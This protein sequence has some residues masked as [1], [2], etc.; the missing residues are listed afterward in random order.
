MY[1]IQDPLLGR[2]SLELQALAR[3]DNEG[4]L[5][6]FRFSRPDPELQLIAVYGG[7][8]GKR[9]S[10][11]GD[12]GADPHDAFELKT[13][14]C[15]YNRYH[16]R[17][18]AFQLWYGASLD[19][20]S[21][22]EAALNDPANRLRTFYGIFPEEAELQLGN[23]EKP[24]DLE[25][26]LKA[27]P[28]PDQPLLLA[29]IPLNEEQVFFIS[30]GA[31]LLPEASEN[32]QIPSPEK[33]SAR[34]RDNSLLPGQKELEIAYNQALES[35]SGI[36]GRLKITCPDPYINAMGGAL[37]M[38]ADAIWESP[39]YLHGSIGWRS[40]L[41]GWRGAYTGD[42]LGWHDRAREHFRAY[43]ASQMTL[44]PDKGVIMDTALNLARSAKVAGSEM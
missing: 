7:A 30:L 20:S 28:Q 21:L 8:R 9:F 23:A 26:L 15:R 29:R 16:I 19:I 17:G 35:A 32:E 10:R 38:A 42:V 41:A 33:P 22:T 5:F 31:G 3:Y 44:P 25:H 1:S 24:K 11:E 12:M 36:A 14:Y 13:A 39:S 40:R 6:R 18:S 37:A 27:E 34:G 4:S 43:G 2:G